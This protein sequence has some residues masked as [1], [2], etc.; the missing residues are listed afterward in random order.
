MDTNQVMQ[1]AL[2]AR[3]DTD[4]HFKPRVGDSNIQYKQDFGV[5]R[6]H[7]LATTDHLYLA[8]PSLNTTQLPAI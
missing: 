7:I 2:L 6:N 1:K 8:T 5:V 4:Q 3:K